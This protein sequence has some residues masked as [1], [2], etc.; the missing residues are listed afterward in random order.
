MGSP[1][2]GSAV[3]VRLVDASTLFDQVSGDF[4]VFLILKR[5]FANLVHQ[6]NI[7][8]VIQKQ[9]HHFNRLGIRERKPAIHVLSVG[10]C[11][12]FKQHPRD[13]KIIASDGRIERCGGVALCLGVEVSAQINQRA[14]DFDLFPSRLHISAGCS[15]LR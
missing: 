9:L 11:A 1:A 4:W 6:M 7:R 10:V 8:A 14:Y 15:L 5:I 13:F 2:Q 12:R 3:S